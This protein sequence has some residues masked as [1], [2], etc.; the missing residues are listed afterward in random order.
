MEFIHGHL[1]NYL[2]KRDKL[3]SIFSDVYLQKQYKML[4][5]IIYN[6][7]PIIF[8]DENVN[9]GIKAYFSCIHYSSRTLMKVKGHISFLVR[10]MWGNSEEV[11]F[12]RRQQSY[13][14]FYILLEIQ[15]S[16][17]FS[18]YTEVE[19]I[20]HELK[21]SLWRPSESFNVITVP[22]VSVWALHNNFPPI[23]C[24]YYLVRQKVCPKIRE[25]GGK[26]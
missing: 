22:I 24:L 10:E 25:E 9:F 16:Q 23:S 8:L 14:T 6:L 15:C 5:Y 20:L 21:F 3:K 4:F 11:F 19:C 2:L 17:N 12:T 7:Q 26:E 1:C 13:N 18:R